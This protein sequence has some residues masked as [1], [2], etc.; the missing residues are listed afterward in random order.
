MFQP[1][2]LPEP[3][4]A[5]WNNADSADYGGTLQPDGAV[6]YFTHMTAGGERLVYSARHQDGEFDPAGPVI[7]NGQPLRG[8]DVQISPDGQGL[9]FKTRQN[10][11]ALE[12]RADGNIYLAQWTGD[13]WAEPAPLP[14]A[15]NSPQDEFYPVL[16]ASGTLYF[17][18]QDEAGNYDIFSSQWSET[19]YQQ[20]APLPANINT[21]ALESDAYIAPD[22]S[23][24]IF[25]RMGH[26]NAIGLS[27]MFIAFRSDAGWTEPVML[28]PPLNSEGLDGS[29]FYDARER[30]LYFTSTRNEPEAR[31]GALDI[32]SA[33][34]NPDDWR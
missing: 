14:D 13:G 27:D 2:P 6:F 8:S 9:I 4:A 24:M 17:S 31:G 7:I 22:E 34:F 32:Y 15:V 23:F 30:R 5:E 25:V 1:G 10:L 18:R 3:V 28:P 20:A 16:A 33:A 26:S 21:S 29:P 19:G 12:G 11:G